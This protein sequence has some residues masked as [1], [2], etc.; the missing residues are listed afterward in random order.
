MNKY[1]FWKQKRKSNSFPKC[2]L[3][4]AAAVHTAAVPNLSDGSGFEGFRVYLQ[5]PL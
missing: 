1:L 3:A 4:T 2:H 5:S